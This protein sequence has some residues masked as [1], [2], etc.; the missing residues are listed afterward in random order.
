MS[1]ILYTGYD[2]FVKKDLQR[3]Y[4]G[5]ELC[6]LLLCVL[7]VRISNVSAKWD[8]RVETSFSDDVREVISHRA[9]GTCFRFLHALHSYYDTTAINQ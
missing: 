8:L 1:D 3:T 5:N 7:V 2:V 4:T 9:N 6:F